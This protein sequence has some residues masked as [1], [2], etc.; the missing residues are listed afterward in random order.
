MY[1]MKKNVNFLAKKNYHLNNLVL[2]IIRHASKTNRLRIVLLSPVF[3]WCLIYSCIEIRSYGSHYQLPN[4]NK[5][6][7]AIK[8]A[9]RISFPRNSHHRFLNVV[10]SDVIRDYDYLW[11]YRLQ[12]NLK[13]PRLLI[14]SIIGMVFSV[15]KRKWIQEE[16]EKMTHLVSNGF[17]VKY[18]L[19]TIR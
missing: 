3:Y 12:I 19:Q 17:G 15:S 7:D 14:L 9:F 18:V 4:W 10:R 5:V 2:I 11:F 13:I 6:F 8:L 16:T 1:L